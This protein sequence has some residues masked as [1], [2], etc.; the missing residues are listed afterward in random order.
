MFS[1]PDQI[2]PESLN[3]SKAVEHSDFTDEPWQGA[4]KTGQVSND[5]SR[6]TMGRNSNESQ[7][8]IHVDDTT[9]VIENWRGRE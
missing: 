6:R 3:H 7:K 5:S 1:N 2:Q 8:V 9:L 4:I